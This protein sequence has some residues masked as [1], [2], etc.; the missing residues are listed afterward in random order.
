MASSVIHLFKTVAAFI[1]GA[2][3]LWGSLPEM[4]RVLIALGLCVLLIINGSR[5]D[6]TGVSVTYFFSAFAVFAYI[7]SMGIHMMQ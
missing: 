5:A 7:F 3:G 6:R 1:V 2:L 4:T